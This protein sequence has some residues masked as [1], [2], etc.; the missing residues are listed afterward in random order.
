MAANERRSRR[1]PHRGA[2]DTS[3]EGH[4]A[5]YDGWVGPGG[6]RYHRA[7][8]VPLVLELVEPRP[9][10]HILDVGCGQ[11]VLAPSIARS[12]ARYVGIDASPSLVERAR[13][14]HG[15]D[16]RFLVG[17]ARRLEAVGGLRR[18][19]FDAAVFL[20]SIQDM[21]P[22]DQVL[23]SIASVLRPAARVV[24]LMTHPSF[25]QPRHAGWGYDADRGLIFRRVD[26]Y[27][28]PMAVPM[29]A[30]SGSRPTR[31]FH[32]PLSAYVNALADAGF[33]I[34]AMREVPD[35]PDELRP[36]NRRA[37]TRADA[38]IPLFLA[39]RARRR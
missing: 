29:K 37:A 3:W 28:T 33:A 18:G 8:A 9:G 32:R 34:D 21:D 19:S 1:L 30:L 6:S 39:L 24:I 31:S 13:R 26:A 35:L 11:G 23:G 2:P 25:R 12:G 17:D 36:R 38:E 27:L 10:E 7:T 5:W 22:L 4:A 15:R 16:G 20:L 14:R